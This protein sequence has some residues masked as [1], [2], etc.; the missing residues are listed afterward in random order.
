VSAGHGPI[1][2]MPGTCRSGGVI[3]GENRHTVAVLIS[4]GDPACASRILE[5]AVTRG[6][7]KSVGAAAR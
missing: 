1:R 3:V 2:R 7:S 4:L 5:L 6:I